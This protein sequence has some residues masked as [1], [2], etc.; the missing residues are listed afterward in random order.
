MSRPKAEGAAPDVARGA[1]WIYV[2]YRPGAPIF[3]LLCGNRAKNVAK[4]A[5][6]AAKVG[7]NRT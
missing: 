7:A 1:A 5:R 2:V 4:G 3:A 6:L